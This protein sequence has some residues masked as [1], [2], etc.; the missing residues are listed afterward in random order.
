MLVVE[1][2]D[3]RALKHYA[4]TLTGFESGG[5]LANPLRNRSTGFEAGRRL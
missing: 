4:H 1:V 2:Y 5:Q 3:T